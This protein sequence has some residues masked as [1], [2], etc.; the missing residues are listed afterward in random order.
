MPEN[1]R[2]RVTAH[3]PICTHAPRV[4]LSLSVALRG[5]RSPILPGIGRRAAAAGVV[6][7]SLPPLV[8]DRGTKKKP[9]RI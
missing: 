1:A 6:P 3:I 2:K 7:L 5:A 9:C 4:P 8:P